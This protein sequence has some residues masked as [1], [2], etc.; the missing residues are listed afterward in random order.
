MRLKQ[1]AIAFDQLINAILGGYADESISAR[2]W[3]LSPCQPY[4]TL[5][6]VIDFLFRPFGKDHCRK[7]Y[8]NRMAY[9]PKTK[10]AP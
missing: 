5:R 6:I 10:D 3:R 1:I 8:E 4:S 7:A 9:F 2:C